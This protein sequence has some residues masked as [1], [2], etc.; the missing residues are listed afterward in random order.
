[1]WFYKVKCKKKKLKYAL[2]YSVV[3]VLENIVISDH[4]NLYR[5]AIEYIGIFRT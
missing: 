2:F 3:F 5:V 1:M 4:I